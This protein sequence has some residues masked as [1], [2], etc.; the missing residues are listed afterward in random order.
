MEGSHCQMMSALDGMAAA[1]LLGSPHNLVPP[2]DLGFPDRQTLSHF[3]PDHQGGNWVPPEPHEGDCLGF[4]Q[5]H[6]GGRCASTLTLERAHLWV[7]G[8]IAAALCSTSLTY[9]VETAGVPR[10]FLQCG[11]L[12]VC[13]VAGPVKPSHLRDV[14]CETQV[15]AKKLLGNI[16]HW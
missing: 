3:P 14:T 2:G 13:W 5:S 16:F 4:V 9:D 11:G 10:P 12:N 8:V 15:V 1:S 7:Y 6:S